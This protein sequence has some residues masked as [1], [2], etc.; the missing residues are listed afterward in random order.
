MIRHFFKLGSFM[1]LGILV[2]SGAAG[3]DPPSLV[4]GG[5]AS[6]VEGI[7]FFEKKIRPLLVEK[8][9]RC[10]SSQAEKLKGGL[11]LDSQPGMLKGG[12]S[13][14][15]IVPGDPEKSR[16]IKA[17]RYTDSDLKMPPTKKLSADEIAALEA[18]VKRGAPDPR[19][20]LAKVPK[21]LEH[22]QSSDWAFQRPKNPPLPPVKRIG[23]V[24]NP[25]DSFILT[26]L[27]AKGLSPAP[28][29][30][31][32]TLL[33]RVTFDLLGLPPKP[34]EIDAFLAD[35]SPEAFARVVDRL[36]ASPQYGER[37]GRHWLD[38]VRYTDDFEE[39]WRYR[40]W[41]VKS[42]ND[43]LP[44][45]EFVRAQIA[46]DLYPAKELGQ[47][48]AD[49][50]IAT[51]LLTIGPWGGIDR[52]KRLTDIVDD[53]IDTIGRSFMG[54]TLA[55]ARCHD[56]KFDPIPTADYYGLAGIFFSS[57]IISDKGYLSHGTARLRIP[58][59]PESEV[60]KHKK[61]MTRLHEAKTKLQTAV[62]H[63]YSEFAK[64]LLPQT[65][66]YFIASWE[67]DRR[68]MDQANLSMEDFA[69]QRGLQ[70]FALAQWHEYLAGKQLG[71]YRLLKMPV[72]D[73]D[74]EAGIQAWRTRAE[75][76]WWAV[77]TT[78]NEV[79]IE[80]FTLPARTISVNPGYEGGA[81]AWKSP[82]AGTVR[83]S[84][85]LTDGD[86]F[87]GVGVSWIVDQ[88]TSAGRR[89]LSSGQLP[90]GG[91]KKLSQGRN[92]ER[93][94]HVQVQPGDQIF[95]HVWLREG[96]AHYD[97]TNIDFKI[98][99]LDNSAEWD[100]VRDVA[101]NFL[102]ANP[103]SDSHGHSGVWSFYDLAESNRGKRMPAFEPFVD[104]WQSMKKEDRG[105]VEKIAK[106]IQAAIDSARPDS[107]LVHDLSGVRS[108]FW[109][110]KRD[111]AKY[112]SPESHAALKKLSQQLADLQNSAPA[113]PSAHGIQEGG[114]HFSLY[115]G[116][117]D[118]PIH[119]RGS[120]EQL[121]QKVPRHF[122]RI[123]AG[124]QQPSINKGSGRLELAQWLGSPDHPLT[125]RVMV[126]RIWQ[127]H[128]EEGLVR[129]PSN[130]G[131]MGAPPT[132]PELLDYLANQ[133]IASGWS[134]KAM[135][136]L[137]LLSAT[138]QQSSR[139]SKES[140]CLD[141]E[142]RLF[143]RM[144]RRRLEAEA[145][146]DTL[147]SV[148]SRLNL[149]P[150]GRAEH[151]KSAPRRMLYLNA[152]RGDRSGF[153]ALFDGANASI[154]IEKRTLSTVAPQALF[155]MN[156]GLVAESARLLANRVEIVSL[157][158]PEQRIAALYRLLFGREPTAEEI[159]IGCRFIREGEAPAF[160]NLV[161]PQPLTVAISLS[162]AGS[163]DV[164]IGSGS[165]GAPS[166]VT[167]WE[168]YAQALL[169]S[170]EFLFV[171]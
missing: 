154:H 9:Y 167:P 62:D 147:F 73:Y 128:F 160:I 140:L 166:G 136:R 22:R 115:P 102:D 31:K 87:D 3:G 54:L 25:I 38:L 139:A 57:H 12:N 171:D 48:N 119:V 69:S 83:I 133:F 104:L 50:I 100:L 77:N 42:V 36:L 121:G 150:G 34:E 63:H 49:G 135:H 7:E 163:R 130:F 5:P 20:E 106:A 117:Q 19:R 81:V 75:R 52:K 23:W 86:P 97:I 35:E 148:S 122:P 37:W 85:Q 156:S 67:Y 109:V 170:N 155:L 114:L 29:A 111:D 113:I 60:E 137:I 45:D 93:L 79:G 105:E 24:K 98:A 76:P 112:L 103:H 90:N 78:R 146:R 101:D 107:P 1:L 131:R 116:F 71:E 82:M 47:V 55:C 61:H 94:T 16:L 13:G 99:S 66:K 95:L 84:G 10:H 6:D 40:D 2:A 15:A 129:T 65:G 152:S 4:A 169:L 74:G 168:S 124:E 89:E 120:Y 141:P 53:Q 41:V 17:I 161:N 108:P 44:Y 153:G 127:H 30:D 72:R 165:A 43:D 80:T 51:T 143:G 32:R 158:K 58:L 26:K 151:E 159:E 18:W 126:N 142:N 164:K 70:G 110:N 162:L 91:R 27:E 138:Y 28:P 144:N 157:E 125:A 149:R 39:A 134:V 88:V 132:H 92:P 123:L 21:S 64:N 145:V 68:P 59:V 96:D 14:P 118:V 11:Y 56:H 33:R 46:G 8:C